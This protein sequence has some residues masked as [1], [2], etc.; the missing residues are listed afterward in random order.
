M[1]IYTY[2]HA[3][4]AP[5]M[6][7]VRFSN[8]AKVYGLAS[9]V[10]SLLTGRSDGGLQAIDPGTSGSFLMY[11]S[12]NPTGISSSSEPTFVSVTTPTITAPSDGDLT[13][14]G[15]HVIL[16]TGAPTAA[17][18]AATK[19]Y[20]DSVAAGLDIKQAVRAKTT[21]LLAAGRA[22]S[23]VL[24]AS[25]AGALTVDGV[26]LLAGDR[27]LVDQIGSPLDADI[28]QVTNAGGPAAQWVLTRAA[29]AAGPGS[30]VFVTE[31]A[32][33]SDRGYVVTS[34]SIDAPKIFSRFTTTG[35]SGPAGTVQVSDGSGGFAAGGGAS[36]AV[37]DGARA[38]LAGTI[39]IAA[40]PMVQK[41]TGFIPGAAGVTP[42]LAAPLS[43]LTTQ[44][45]SGATVAASVAQIVIPTGAIFIPF[46]YSTWCCEFT[47]RTGSASNV[48][49]DI[50]T[51]SGAS[52]VVRGLNLGT[53]ATGAT[54]QMTSLWGDG[55]GVGIAPL[56]GTI[57]VGVTSAVG[58]AHKFR[59]GILG[60]LVETQ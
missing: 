30:F 60:F 8:P 42:G 29:A 32:T 18:H 16:D 35:S 46:G 9:G 49:V 6:P 54:A 2:M 58:G 43:I 20:V 52:N 53:P 11:D 48:K 41:T 3:M 17:S 34:D 26:A 22:V 13:L 24:T 51:T 12:A 50:G 1:R 21:T 4:S 59:L 44:A 55:A 7:S 23:G 39:Q 25:A 27:V 33:C 57:H 5:D 19:S 38:T 56:Q 10:G 40:I 31:G 45:F 14:R 28:Y 37:G 47:S 15:G 36:L